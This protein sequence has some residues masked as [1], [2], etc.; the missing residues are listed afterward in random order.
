MNNAILEYYQRIKN[1]SIVVGVW[2]AK[3]YE[4][5]VHGLESK[6]FEFDQRKANNAIN[7]IEEHCFHVEGELAPSPLKLEL[8][9][10]AFVSCIFGI[11]DIETKKRRPFSRG[12]AVKEPR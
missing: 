11:V 8:W 3:L 1:G 10:R 5:I 12:I 6:E 7:F 4:Y 9:Q 2:I